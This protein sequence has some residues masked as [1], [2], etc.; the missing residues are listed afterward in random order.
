MLDL[1]LLENKLL[2]RLPSIKIFIGSVLLMNKALQCYSF[3][4]TTLYR[5]CHLLNTNNFQKTEV[6]YVEINAS[7]NNQRL[8]NFLLKTL[9]T[10]PKSRIYRIIRKGEVRVNKKR[11]KAGYKL[12]MGDLVR[13]P[14]IR[15]EPRDESEIHI[16]PGLIRSI[17]KAVL[18]EDKHLVVIDKPTGLAVHSGTGISFGIID[19]MR[20]IRPQTE[21]ELVH[22]LDRDT[23]GCLLLAKHRQ[24]LLEMQACMQNNSLKK[25]YIA[26]VKGRWPQDKRKL[27]HELKKSTL[28]NGERRVYVDAEGQK[29]QTLI[30]RV[31][32]ADDFSR[33][34]IQILTGRTHQIRVHCQF[35]GHEIAGD[36]KYGDVTFNKLMKKKGAGRLMLHASRLELPHTDFSPEIVINANT[37]AAFE[38]LAEL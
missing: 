34:T 12:N 35:E 15:L 27:S 38:N 29:A 11:S 6:V 30:T 28:P 31:D 37:P 20:H 4:Y 9:K 1:I 13:I 18:Y 2:S 17:E 3:E 10:V 8:D 22:R 32:A 33:L 36:S 19:I 23:S 7:Q 25:T 14:P 26:V 5:Y 16:P 24:S 21:I